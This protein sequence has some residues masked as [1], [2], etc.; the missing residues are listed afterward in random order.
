MIVKFRA[1]FFLLLL[2]LLAFS[3]WIYLAHL[4]WGVPSMRKTMNVMGSEENLNRLVP[5]MLE[6]RRK[7]YEMMGNLFDM[8]KDV[9]QAHEDLTHR[10]DLPYFEPIPRDGVLDR[11]RNYLIGANASDEQITLVA[12]GGGN[13][14]K[15]DFTP[16]NT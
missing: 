10:W 4:G 11:M 16:A 7:Y 1:S 6:Q 5:G 3:A 12:I 15:L 14:Q 2:V 8:S 9:R 13:P